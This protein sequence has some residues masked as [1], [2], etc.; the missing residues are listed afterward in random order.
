M[1]LFPVRP[2]SSAVEPPPYLAARPAD[3]ARNLM[4]GRLILANA[5]DS[6]GRAGMPALHRIV[7]VAADALGAIGARLVNGSIGL[8]DWFLASLDQVVVRHFAGMLALEPSSIP[9]PA[10]I[11][12]VEPLIDRQAGFLARFRRQLAAGLDRTKALISRARLY[13]EAI[14][15][16][17]MNATREAEVEMRARERRVLDD[18]SRHCATCPSLAAMGWQP[19]GTLPPIGASECG[20]FC[21]CYFVYDGGPGGGPGGPAVAPTRPTKAAVEAEV[22][23]K[24]ARAYAAEGDTAVVADLAALVAALRTAD[25]G[26]LVGPGGTGPSAKPGAY[27]RF[28]E[29]LARARAEGIAVEMPRLGFDAQGNPTVIDGRHRI[30]VLSDLGYAYLPVTVDPAESG[31]FRRRFGPR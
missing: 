31:E 1:A 28:L 13:G 10:A 4:R 16:G 14:W 24:F 25:P 7:D 21:R 20:Q 8:A 18:G 19:A 6:L 17:V 2:I 27:Q 3:R 11:D 29:F 12:A 26:E 22:G 5:R 23:V 15:A 30:A 9:N